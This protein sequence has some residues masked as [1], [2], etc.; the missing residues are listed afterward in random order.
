MIPISVPDGVPVFIVDDM[1]TDAELNLIWEELRFLTSPR[2]L[3]GAAETKAAT[4]EGG[5]YKKTASGIFLDSFYAERSYSNILEAN[6]KLFT[7]EIV[8]HA[9]RLSI[10]YGLLTQ[11]NSDFT[12]I[13]YYDNNQTYKAHTD[14]TVFTAITMFYKEPVQ[15]TG[16]DLEFPEFDLRVEKRNNRMVMFPGSLQHAVTPVAM[17]NSYP[18]FSG[19]GRYAMAQF[20]HIS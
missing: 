1:Y 12:L 13:N 8:Q 18:P 16:G 20:L 6:R 3:L 15:F 10:F 14:I 19:Y 7:D 2:R 17:Q 9:L 11:I 5:R 4:D